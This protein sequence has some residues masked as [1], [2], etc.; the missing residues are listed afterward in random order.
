M[1]AGADV[2]VRVTTTE[3]VSAEATADVEAAAA[4]E[5]APPGEQPKKS[6]KT[7]AS[8]KCPAPGTVKLHNSIAGE[9]SDVKYL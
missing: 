5:E 1:A 3:P 7:H 8:T 9:T 2:A 6:W 4:K